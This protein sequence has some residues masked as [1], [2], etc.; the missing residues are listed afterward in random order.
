MAA[1]RC[2][3]VAD[4]YFYLQDSPEWNQ[5]QLSAFEKVLDEFQVYQSKAMYTA[6][7]L[8]IQ[9]YDNTAGVFVGNEIITFGML[10]ILAG[11]RVC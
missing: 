2:G 6:M 11:F 9:A 5:T 1:A 4:A 7:R 10:S 8:T 3:I